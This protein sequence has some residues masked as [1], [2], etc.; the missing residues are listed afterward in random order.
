MDKRELEAINLMAKSPQGQ[1]FRVWMEK[2][3]AEMYREVSKT[4]DVNA[5]L[6]LQGRIANME[7][8]TD[9]LSD[10]G[11]IQVQKELIQAEKLQQEEPQN[12]W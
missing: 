11:L 3:L 5:L 6:K 10:E 12:R 1:V 8:L 2:Q 7:E 9:L 4:H